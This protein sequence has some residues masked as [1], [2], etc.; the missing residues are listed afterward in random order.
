[1]LNY[2]KR[3]FLAIHANKSCLDNISDA[4]IHFTQQ[5]NH[6]N[7]ILNIKHVTLLLSTQI[8]NSSAKQITTKKN[9]LFPLL[10]HI[11]IRHRKYSCSKTV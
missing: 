7:K 8:L 11:T 3:I 10:I 4:Q 6:Y 2:Y 1:M 5:P 9:S